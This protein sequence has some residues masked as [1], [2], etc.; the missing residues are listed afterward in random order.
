MTRIAVQVE[1]PRAVE[2]MRPPAS[3]DTAVARPRPTWKS[4]LTM[5]RVPA[6]NR[7]SRYS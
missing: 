1:I 2:R 4:R 3:T 5:A 7:S 6:S